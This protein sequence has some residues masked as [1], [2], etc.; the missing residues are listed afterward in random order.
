M[1]SVLEVEYGFTKEEIRSSIRR[2][3][4]PV[5]YD[6]PVIACAVSRIPFGEERFNSIC[7]A[8]LLVKKAVGVKQ[9]GVLGRSKLARI[10]VGRDERIIL[11]NIE[12]SDR[13]TDEA[14]KDKLR[15]HRIKSKGV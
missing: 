8:K 14:W 9:I 6:K 1:F 11:F 13:I 4:L 15:I 2:I 10:E 7:R 12:L 3:R 5:Y